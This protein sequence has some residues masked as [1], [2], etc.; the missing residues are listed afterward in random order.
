MS[1]PHFPG[2]PQRGMPNPAAPWGG[3]SPGPVAPPSILTSKPTAA[4]MFTAFRRRWRLATSLGL[5]VGTAAAVIAWYL[6]SPLSYTASTTIRVDPNAPKILIETKEG[7]TD[8]ATYLRVQVGHIKSRT[9]L[10]SA[11]N[12]PKV[13]KLDFIRQQPDPI[14]WLTKELLVD[15]PGP[16]TI[17]ISMIGRDADGL[18]TLLDAIRNSYLQDVGERENRQRQERRDKLKRLQDEYE[19]DLKGK[20]NVLRA[21]L[22]DLGGNGD[23]FL[24][25]KQEFDLIELNQMKTQLA[26]LKS[27]L[28]AA[29]LEDGITPNREKPDKIVIPEAA[30]EEAVNKDESVAGYEKEIAKLEKELADLRKGFPNNYDKKPIYVDTL[31]K[32]TK[33]RESLA[34]RKAELV[35]KVTTELQTQ[36]RLELGRVQAAREERVAKLQNLIKFLTEQVEKRSAQSQNLGKKVIDAEA[37][38]E[39]LELDEQVWKKVCSELAALKVEFDAPP[40]VSATEEPPYAVKRDTLAAKTALGVG[41]GGFCLVLLGISFLEFRARRLV[42]A[43][44]LSQGLRL[45]VIGMMPRIRP[46]HGR[47]P[48]SGDSREEASQRLLIESVDSALAVILHASRQSAHRVVMIT[49]AVGGE[50]KTMLSAHLTAS[51]ARAGWRALLVDA[52]FRRPSL[53]TV[54]GL[55]DQAGLSEVLRGEADI[56]AVMQPGPMDGLW[57]ISAGRCDTRSMQA[58]AQGA[59]R[60]LFDQIREEFDLIVVDSAPV[61]PVVDSQLIAQAVDGVIL[62]VLRDVSRLPLIHAAY[63]RLMLFKVSLLGAVVHGADVGSYGVKYPYTAIP[64]APAPTN[65]EQTQ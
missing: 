9:V 32:Q 17:R 65:P 38:K 43:E 26:E 61:L 47:T 64:A 57:V 5:V 40:R 21:T 37:Q 1:G 23:K 34:N 53:Q 7:R 55:P 63:E 35:T 14:D 30:I 33:L 28:L 22:E 58:L 41:L 62:S 25:L 18:T 60:G 52:D 19:R 16:D 6:M 2:F 4:G 8:S 31:A 59:L 50:G 45:P 49:S 20:R 48:P 51:M 54:F 46:G 44:E 56:R 10:N 39:D 13:A 29:T 27:Q 3:A 15:T 12:D 24:A 11:L 42:D 36:R